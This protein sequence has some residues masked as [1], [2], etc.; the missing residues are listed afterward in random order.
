MDPAVD[1][2]LN[3][4]KARVSAQATAERSA[5]YTINL[6]PC[7]KCG[8]RNTRE[9]RTH[10]TIAIVLGLFALA[11]AGGISYALFTITRRLETSSY[12]ALVVAALIC[13]L[14]GLLV[15][16]NAMSV[17][18]RAVKETKFTIVRARPSPVESPPST[19]DTGE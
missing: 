19:P 15:P 8:R 10:F 14:M 17:Y 1:H 18:D 4:E 3:A 9:V 16:F 5:K 7:P 13:G 12:V 6:A 2:G 11:G